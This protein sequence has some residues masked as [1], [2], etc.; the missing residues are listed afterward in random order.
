MLYVSVLCLPEESN[1]KL[2][3]RREVS[4]Y[5]MEKVTAYITNIKSSGDQYHQLL[6]NTLVHFFLTMVNHPLTKK[7]HHFHVHNNF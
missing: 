2:R 6:T 7:F 1:S 3:S 4:K 5:D